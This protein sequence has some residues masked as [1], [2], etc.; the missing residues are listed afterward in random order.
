VSIKGGRYVR[1]QRA[2]AT[3]N[4]L[5]ALTAAQELPPLSLADALALTCVLRHDPG[6]FEAA[7]LRWH[8]RFVREVRRRPGRRR[9]Q[10]AHRCSRLDE[11]SGSSC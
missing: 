3:G 11:G 2:L 6:R 8:G 5:I 1:F 10:R 7:A 9:N 4:P